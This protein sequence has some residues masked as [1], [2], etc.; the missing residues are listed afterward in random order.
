MASESYMTSETVAARIG[1]A[2]TGLFGEASPSTLFSEPIQHGDDLVITAVAWERAG[3][4][5]FGSGQGQGQGEE[6]GSGEGGG[7]GGFSQGRP[8][9]V[10]RVTPTSVEVTPVIDFT[11]IG[12]T[13]LLASIGVWRALSR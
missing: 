13:L 4:F 3:G 2:L 11:K 1:D 10:I 5:G 8:V 6:S 9:A 12:V 7:G